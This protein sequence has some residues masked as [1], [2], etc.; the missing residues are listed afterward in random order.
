[1][2]R[3]VFIKTLLIGAALTRAIKAGGEPPAIDHDGLSWRDVSFGNGGFA[4]ITPAQRTFVLCC[5]ADKAK[6]APLSPVI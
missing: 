2:T 1:M 6:R 5:L 4:A 3:S